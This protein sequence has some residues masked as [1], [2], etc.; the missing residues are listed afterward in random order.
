MLGRIKSV[1]G[2]L[3]VL[4]YDLNR[5]YFLR[6]QPNFF[7]VQLKLKSTAH[8]IFITMCLLIADKMYSYH[9]TSQ[10]DH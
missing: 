2:F 5:E 10:M 8:A 3:I 6:I 9:N 4:P 1:V 7:D